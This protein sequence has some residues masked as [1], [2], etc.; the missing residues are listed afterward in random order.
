MKIFFSHNRRQKL[1]AKALIKFLP[2]HIESWLD[3]KELS[4]GAKLESEII[5][6]I[7]QCDFVVIIIDN[8]SVKSEWVMRELEWAIKREETLGRTFIIPVLLDIEAWEQITNV[9]LKSRKYLSCQDFTEDV[10]IKN[11]A[12][13][14]ILEL[15]ALLSKEMNKPI[16]FIDNSDT[17]LKI[18][19]EAEIYLK[20]VSKTIILSLYPYKRGNPISIND[21]YTIL[22]GK[23]N[24]Q[25]NS[26]DELKTM[27]VKLQKQFSLTGVAF[28][29]DFLYIK[30]ER[31]EQK[32]DLQHDVKTKI[33]KKAFSYIQSD[34]IIALDAG[35]TTFEVAKM[36]GNSIRMGVLENLTVITNFLPAANELLKV[37]SDLS[38][39]DKS[40]L[41]KVFLIGG[42]VRPVSHAIVRDKRIIN[43][44]LMTDFSVILSSLGGADIAFVG[45]NGLYKN[46]GFAL[47]NDFEIKNKSEMLFHSKKKFILVDISKFKKQDERIFASF[48]DNLEIITCIE[49][50]K[51]PIIC[52]VN[53]MLSKTNSKIIYA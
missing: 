25:I 45:A 2:N 12:Q 27:L 42:R 1:F 13:N 23:D 34:M 33:A 32:S 29:G 30:Q 20:K 38:L 50:D 48:E 41:L 36:I 7:S 53:E 22:Q 40:E 44:E 52:Q 6:T 37:A 49:D 24:I 3:E 16:Q 17:S 10:S 15:F 47:Q 51:D 43:S 5:E 18:I 8:D 9:N 39:D 28:D 14:L 26:I 46:L 31:F 4:A 19:E 11:L 21:F 35:S